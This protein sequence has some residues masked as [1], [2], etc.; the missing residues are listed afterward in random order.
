M[1]LLRNVNCVSI[2]EFIFLFLFFN[3]FFFII[4]QKVTYLM[5]T[6]NVKKK[7]Y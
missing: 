6:K 3:V 2:V 4:I 7:K 5:T 1:L